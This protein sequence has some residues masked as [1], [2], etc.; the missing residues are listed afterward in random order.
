MDSTPPRSLPKSSICR[1]SF[2]LFRISIIFCLNYERAQ[3]RTWSTSPPH[4]AQPTPT[5]R[6]PSPRSSH[7]PHCGTPA[8]APQP[9]PPA[10]HATPYISQAC[11]PVV[12]IARATNASPCCACHTPHPSG[13][14]YAARAIGLNVS[15]AVLSCLDATRGTR[16]HDNKS[17][18][19][20]AGGARGGGRGAIPRPATSLRRGAVPRFVALQV[21]PRDGVGVA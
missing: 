1:L 21:L 20:R 7:A 8:A 17:Y 18:L 16:T 10:L 4:T 9:A 3:C 13:S 11:S 19:L 6:D 15:P 5:T 12:R 14:L 2:S